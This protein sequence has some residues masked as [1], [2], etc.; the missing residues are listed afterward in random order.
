TNI[1]W[2]ADA[3]LAAIE[4]FGLPVGS[5]PKKGAE[6]INPDG[7][8]SYVTAVAWVARMNAA[9]YLGHNNWRL[10]I[11][12][13]TTQDY[14]ETYTE[15]GELYSMELGGRAG[16]AIAADAGPFHNFQ[17]YYYWSGNE[18]QEEMSANLILDKPHAHET[19]SFGSGYR[20]SNVD[21]NEMYVIPVF[22]G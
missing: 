13:S 16:S 3:D 7:S 22:D 9:D 11:N 10:P 2:L 14:D 5:D 18:V 21:P 6:N 20:S 1:N 12:F 8:M 17:P 19:F 4:R 15:L